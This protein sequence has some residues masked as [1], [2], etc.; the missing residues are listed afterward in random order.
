MVYGFSAEE[1]ARLPRST[2]PSTMPGAE[3]FP[4]IPGMAGLADSLHAAGKVLAVA[5]SKRAALPFE[6][7]HAR[8]GVL[9]HAL[10]STWANLTTGPI[11]SRRPS[12][13]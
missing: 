11:P 13:A 5:S 12:A 4:A 9:R 1:A 7:A 8:V 10:M 6:S 2:A 3:A